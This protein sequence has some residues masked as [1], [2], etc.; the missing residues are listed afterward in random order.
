MQKQTIIE[1]LIAFFSVSID[2]GSMG[3]QH[4]VRAKR[5]RRLAY[6]QR[7]KA[8]LRVAATRPMP[9]KQQTQKESSPAQ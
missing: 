8:T 1:S 7:K 9:S 4:R 6:L 5:R 2:R 3:Q